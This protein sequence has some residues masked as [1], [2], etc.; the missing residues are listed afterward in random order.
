MLLWGEES[1]GL[2]QAGQGLWGPE[3]TRKEQLDHLVMLSF[4]ASWPSWP[5]WAVFPRYRAAH[6]LGAG[7]GNGRPAWAKSVAAASAGR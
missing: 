2:G 4:L 6:W 3:A 7:L 5:S 1:S